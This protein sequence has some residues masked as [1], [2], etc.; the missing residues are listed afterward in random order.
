MHC[1]WDNGQDR[2]Q[3]AERK[4][5]VYSLQSERSP[6]SLVLTYKE[7]GGTLDLL[8]EENGVVAEC[9]IRTMEAFE[10]LD[11]DFLNNKSS[12]K[13][14]LKS[15]CMREAFNELDMTS[16]VLELTLLPPPAT[17]PR[18]R[19]TTYGLAGTTHFDLPRS[20]D[21]VEVFESSSESPRVARYRL[22]LLRSATSRVLAMACRISL[23]INDRGFLSMQHMINLPDGQAA[24]VE[25]FCVPDEEED[26]ESTTQGSQ[27]SSSNIEVPSSSGALS[28]S[29]TR[30]QQAV[31]EQEWSD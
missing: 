8:L 17:Q 5:R 11:F 13:V 10:I 1:Q 21:Q 30:R 18:I 29:S 7:F 26:D 24:F 4:T 25:F 22:S 12:D 6:T 20:S 19:L 23:R 15:E 31:L 16:E 3:T 14:I 2:T 9:N 27:K 28:A